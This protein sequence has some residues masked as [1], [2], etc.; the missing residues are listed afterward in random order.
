MTISRVLLRH[1]LDDIILNTHLFRPFRLVRF[2][3]PSFW[4]RHRARRPR[5]ERI[6]GALED[7]GPIFVKFGQ[8]LST[9]RDLLPDDLSEELAKLQDQVPPF[10]GDQAVA[11]IEQ[12]FNLPIEQI[13]SEFEREPLASASIAQV[14]KA[15]LL[16]GREMVVKVVRPNIEKVIRRDLALL[17]AIADKVEKYWSEGKRLR[18]HE[19]VE[20]FDKNIIDELDLLREAAN[21]SELRRNFKDSPLLYI[22]EVDWNHCRKKVMVMERIHGMP[23]TNMNDLKAMDIDF[24]ALAEMGVEIFFTQVFRDN[25]FHADMHP[26]NIFVSN[27]GQYIAIDFGIMGSLSNDDQRYLAENFLAFFNRDYYRVAELHVQSGWVP[28]DTR[29]DDF[30]SAIRSVCEPIFEKPLHEISFGQLLLRL[31]QTARRFNMEVQPQ[32]VLLQKTLLN[33]E[34]L[35]RQLYPQLDLWDTAKPFLENWMKEQLGFRSFAKQVKHNAPL[36]MEQLPEF[37]GHVF[38][39]LQQARHGK[40]RINYQSDTLNR[41]EDKINSQNKTTIQAVISAALLV[42]GAI[43]YSSN[44]M[45]EAQ[46]VSALGIAGAVWAFFK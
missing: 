8:I 45:I 39:V 30:E 2:V 18:P 14:H 28:A 6:R 11:I 42:S 20:E 29:V 43:L 32:L 38:D 17:Y 13:F 15:T 7:L 23:V 3:S 34:G 22:P 25:F 9:R 31:F 12:S 40:L 41:I 1:G 36:W 33:I 19:V 5:G 35:G 21:A 4:L 27:S 44:M 10:P 26:G 24:K 16:D 37:P 46:I